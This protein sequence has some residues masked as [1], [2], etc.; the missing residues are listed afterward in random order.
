LAEKGALFSAKD[1]LKQALRSVAQSLDAHFGG[2]SFSENL[3]AGWMALDEADDFAIQSQRGP[4]VD[5]GVIVEL[6]QTPI[7]KSYNLN[8]ISPVVATQHYYLYAQDRLIAACGGAPVAARALHGLGKV[9]TV[10]AEK[11]SNAEPQHGPKAMAFQQA[12]LIIDPTN[13]LAA[14]E[15]GVLL[16]R[17]GKLE[18]ARGVLQHALAVNPSPETWQNLSVVHHRL[19]EVNLA[20]QSH[21]NWRSLVESPPGSSVPATSGDS[22]IQWVAPQV[23]TVGQMAPAPVATPRPQPRPAPQPATD[24]KKLGILWW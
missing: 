6:H 13:G 2:Q 18:E 17:F 12:A 4:V 3:A 15:L 21:A 23:F 22:M 1:E 16:A 10:L 8:H 9:H 7:L 5:V 19:G 11:S 24:K 14:N 20:A